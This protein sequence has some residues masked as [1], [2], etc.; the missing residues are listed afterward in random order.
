LLRA[1]LQAIRWYALD[2][3]VQ[4]Q[5]Q[6]IEEQRVLLEKEVL[7]LQ[8]FDSTHKQQREA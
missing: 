1:Q 4:T 6:Y 3:A 7:A 8:D 2:S 5:Q